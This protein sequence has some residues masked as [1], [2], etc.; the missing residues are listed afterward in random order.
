MKLAEIIPRQRLMPLIFPDS[1][2]Q[3]V[4]DASIYRNAGYMAVEILCRTPCAIEAITKTCLQMPDLLVGAG[5][6]LSLETAGQAKKAGAKFLVSPGSD[7]VIMDF[8]IANGLQMVPG[9]YSP[10]DVA[11]ALRYGFTIQKLF[12]AEPDGIGRLNAFASPYT[13]TG[14]KMVVGHQI[15]RE[16]APAYLKHPLVAAVIADWLVPLRGTALR[17]ELARTTAWFKSL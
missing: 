13:H 14:V 4:E 17:E 3:V 1:V 8:A 6:V 10:T 2:A 15:V 5:T 11:I 9:V 12:P 7:P 16:N